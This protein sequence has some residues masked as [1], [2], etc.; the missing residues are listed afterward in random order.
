MVLDFWD[1][2]NQDLLEALK[3]PSECHRF[4][5]SHAKHHLR[6][7]MTTGKSPVW[8]DLAISALWLLSSDVLSY[9]EMIPATVDTDAI[10]L[11][12]L[13]VSS[14]VTFILRDLPWVLLNVGDDRVAL[15][16]GTWDQSIWIHSLCNLLH[17]PFDVHW[18]D[19]WILKV[20]V[21]AVLRA[22]KLWLLVYKMFGLANKS[23]LLTEAMLWNVHICILGAMMG[24]CRVTLNKKTYVMS[25]S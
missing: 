16:S 11:N 17:G 19:S 1:D 15:N 12:W 6:S 3:L 4:L 9:I 10:L 22:I 8:S 18:G 24:S 25:N 7:C 14:Q 23:C 21:W 2:V 20:L 13:I 5:A